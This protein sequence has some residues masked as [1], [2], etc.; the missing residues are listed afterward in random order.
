MQ[1]RKLYT[2]EEKRQHV[3]S[4]RAYRLSL[5]TRT[6]SRLICATGSPGRRK[7]LL[8]PYL[9]ISKLILS[10]LTFAADAIGGLRQWSGETMPCHTQFFAKNSR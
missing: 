2:L 8:L 5:P 10:Y 9:S 7:H 3:A 6:I 1:E 4:W